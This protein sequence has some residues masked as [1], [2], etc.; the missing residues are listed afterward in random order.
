[1]FNLRRIVYIY[2]HIHFVILYNYGYYVHVVVTVT[3]GPVTGGAAT[4]IISL[5]DCTRL[6]AD[7]YM[8]VI[9]LYVLGSSKKEQS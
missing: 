3:S 4:V 9:L 5:V 7:P 6:R 1:M 2:L 8:S